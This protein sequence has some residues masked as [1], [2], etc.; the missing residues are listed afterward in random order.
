MAGNAYS[1]IVVC[2]LMTFDDITCLFIFSKEDLSSSYEFIRP[3]STSQELSTASC[4][5]VAVK[6][7]I[8]RLIG[9]KV[10]YF[11][12]G[13][14]PNLISNGKDTFNILKTDESESVK[15]RASTGVAAAWGFHHYL[16]YYCNCHVS[17]SGDQL[18]L[19]DVLPDVN[20]TVTANDRF[21]YYQNVCTTSYSFVWWSFDRWRR[22]IDWMALNGI[23]LAL[24]FNGQEE[25]WRRVYV[26][27]GMKTTEIDAY[28]T[29]PAFFSW[30]RM[31]N[32]RGWGGPLSSSWHDR[33]INLQIQILDQMRNIGITPVLPAFAGQVPRSFKRLFPNSTLEPLP[34]WNHFSDKYCCP[35]FLS[36]EDPLFKTIG[37]LFLNEY[38]SQF[39][40]DHIYNCDSFNEMTPSS[41]DLK[42]LRSVGQSIYKAMSSADEN[43]VWL[44]QGWLFRHNA[45]FWTKKRAEAFLTSVPYGKM[46]VLD[47][48]GEL[49]PQYS[50]L[51]SYFGQPFIWCMLHNFGGTLGMHGTVTQVNEGPFK[52]RNMINST[53]IGTGLTPEGINQNYVMYDLMNEMSWRKKPAELDSWFDNYSIRRY[54]QNSSHAKK[55]WQLLKKSVYNYRGNVQQHGKYIFVHAPDLYLKQDLWYDAN[56]VMFAWDECIKTLE[57]W[58]KNENMP[59]TMLYDIVD[60]SRQSLQLLLDESYLKIIHNF[61]NKNVKEC[62]EECQTF[63]SLLKS[64]EELLSSNE[65]FLLKPWIESAKSIATTTSE[66]E[67]YEKNARNQVTMWG[68][69]GEIKDYA[70]KQWAG[71]IHHYYYPRWELF[72]NYMKK[73]LIS[74][75]HFNQTV[76]AK[77]IFEQVEQPFTYSTDPINETYTANASD[78][79]KKIYSIW[80]PT[81]KNN[82]IKAVMVF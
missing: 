80:R 14:N 47:L 1:L 65:G 13:I 73:T 54:G 79:V 52:A 32:M 59:Y 51:D 50:R 62:L 76:I 11:D 37:K 70:N 22:E 57:M 27:M 66:S 21:R 12:V 46:V 38:I 75:I 61:M 29:G 18:K 5:E 17:W 24:A 10:K 58:P 20:K 74:G 77:D 63:L 3:S 25:I 6:D 72:F 33:S 71:L 69:N 40:T 23:N 55:F 60:L 41:G 45:L 53:M 28:F 15:I 8:Q 82:T 42:Y 44:L 30:G 36:P 48:Q 78:V 26:K 56:D 39:G 34:K 7:L 64:M 49:N 16:K 67:L 2:L 43:A 19:P 31:G 81:F 35:Y 68:P 4:Q 9:D